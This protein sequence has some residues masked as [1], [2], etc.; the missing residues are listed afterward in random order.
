MHHA[1]GRLTKLIA[2][3]IYRG[4][5]GWLSLFAIA[6][7]LAVRNAPQTAPSTTRPDGAVSI[8]TE[9]LLAY[10]EKVEADQE[11]LREEFRVTWHWAEGSAEPPKSFDPSQFVHSQRITLLCSKE[12]YR[13]ELTYLDVHPNLA[14]MKGQVHTFTWD[15][16]E[17][18]LTTLGA[19]SR[20]AKQQSGRIDNEPP[21]EFSDLPINHWCGYWV[22]GNAYFQGYA[23]LLRTSA[24]TGPRRLEEAGESLWQWRIASKVAIHG[25]ILLTARRNEGQIVLHS[26][27]FRV[28]KTAAGLEKEDLSEMFLSARIEFLGELGVRPHLLNGARYIVSRWPTDGSKPSWGLCDM[29]MVKAER[30]EPNDDDFKVP[31]TDNAIIGDTRY[32]IAYQFGKRD[33]NVDGRLFET[34]EPLHGDVGGRLQ[35]WIEHGTP[36]ADKGRRQVTEEASD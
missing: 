5:G 34:H 26:S 20:D 8:S 29:Q 11:N 14:G 6:T 19:H 24:V 21:R 22:H 31:F 1:P 35:W 23:D 10:F 4:F 9:E 25:E 18:R 36:I 3:S 7:S 16:R 32:N 2:I 30:V 33:L 13:A 17:A 27:E 15:G 28:F 12:R